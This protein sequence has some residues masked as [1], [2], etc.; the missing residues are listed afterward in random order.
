MQRAIVVS[1]LAGSLV[2]GFA[3]VASGVAP[4]GTLRLV[5]TSSGGA[6]GG[7]VSEQPGLSGDGTR[8]VFSTDASDI[9]PGLDGVTV[10]YKDLRTGVVTPMPTSRRPYAYN[11]YPSISSDG[12]I[13]SFEAFFDLIPADRNRNADG[14]LWRVATGTLTVPLLA[15]NPGRRTLCCALS[16]DGLGYWAASPAWTPTGN[17]MSPTPGLEISVP[18]VTFV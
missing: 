1:A 8:L 16:R 3:P 5:S 13:V 18:A 14:Y 4:S 2:M 15:V 6:R 7:G 11:S 10:V 17:S 12:R 9:V